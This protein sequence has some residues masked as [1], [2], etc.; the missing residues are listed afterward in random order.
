MST[1][2]PVRKV[3]YIESYFIYEDK[4]KINDILFYFCMY[5]S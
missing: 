4:S 3:K 1:R 5:M 2:F